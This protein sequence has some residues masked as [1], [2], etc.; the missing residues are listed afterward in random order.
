MKNYTTGRQAQM[1]T[2][3]NKKSI[4]V[5]VFSKAIYYNFRDLVMPLSVSGLSQARQDK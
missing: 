4:K 1:I 5:C 3:D 2:K